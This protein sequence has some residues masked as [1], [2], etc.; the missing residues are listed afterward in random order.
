MA[1]AIQPIGQRS[2]AFFRT[3]QLAGLKEYLFEVG[4]AFDGRPVLTL[5]VRQWG[6]DPDDAVAR[7]K[8]RFCGE[9]LELGDVG[10]DDLTY[11]QLHVGAEFVTVR[12]ITEIGDAPFNADEHLRSTRTAGVLVCPNCGDGER[13]SFVESLLGN[14]GISSEEREPE[15]CPGE[16]RSV[17]V[18]DDDGLVAYDGDGTDVNW[19]TGS[20]L[21]DPNRNPL[22]QCRA[23][24]HKWYEPRVRGGK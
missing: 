3:N 21:R 2:A 4:L 5:S 20:P 18:I 24:D 23:C 12:N 6:T 10:D 7:F 22:L 8:E 11:A 9:A 1:R 15:D 13:L 17:G 14:C 16:E 19:D